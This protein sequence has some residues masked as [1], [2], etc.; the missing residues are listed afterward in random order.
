MSVSEYYDIK[1]L[2]PRLL[3]IKIGKRRY[4]EVF[5]IKSYIRKIK[6]KN[7]RKFI[8]QYKI[9]SEPLENKLK[10]IGTIIPIPRKKYKKIFKCYKLKEY[11]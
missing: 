4:I 1:S 7:K 9:K 5:R 3:N 11:E 2:Y 6:V 10:S 8:K